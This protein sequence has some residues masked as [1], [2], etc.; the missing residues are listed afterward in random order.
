M[1]TVAA[2]LTLAGTIAGGLLWW[3]K[4]KAAQNDDPKNQVQKSK[5]ENAQA[6]ADNTDGA[7]LDGELDRLHKPPSG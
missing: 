2:A 5:D 7:R 4:R 6:I 3:I 1:G